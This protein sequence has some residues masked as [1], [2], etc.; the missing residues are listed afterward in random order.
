VLLLCPDPA[1]DRELL[2]TSIVLAVDP[3]PHPGKAVLML[4]GHIAA[5]RVDCGKG[6]S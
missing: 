3:R 6:E 4:A 1:K 2:G 5:A